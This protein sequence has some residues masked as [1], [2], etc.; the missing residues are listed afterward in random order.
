MQNFKTIT[1]FLYLSLIT[2]QVEAEVLFGPEPGKSVM[3][4]KPVCSDI[5]KIGDWKRFKYQG[6]RRVYLNDIQKAPVDGYS[7]FSNVVDSAFNL[8]L[9]VTE[10]YLIKS[11]GTPLSK[12]YLSEIEYTTLD[13]S[14]KSKSDFWGLQFFE[15]VMSVKIS[16]IG[17]C[18][19]TIEL[20]IE[21]V[22]IGK[23][24]ALEFIRK[25]PR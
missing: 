12:K 23:A 15:K 16:L 11:F 7:K 5:A 10:S 19:A 3:D 22:E 14:F 17:D 8:P 24:N 2:S 1:L 21:D 4:Y 20:R 6:Y 25:E 18:I 13:W 9:R